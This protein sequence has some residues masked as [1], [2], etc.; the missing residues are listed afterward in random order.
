MAGIAWSVP[1]LVVAGAAPAVSASTFPAVVVNQGTTSDSGLPV[2]RHP[3][4]GWTGPGTSNT[5]YVG[6]NVPGFASG[7]DPLTRFGATVTATYTFTTVKGATYSIGLDT[8]VGLGWPADRAQ[9]ERLVV[10]VGNTTIAQVTPEHGTQTAYAANNTDTYWAGQG[11]SLQAPS[12]TAKVHHT[13][14]FAAPPNGGTVTITYTFTLPSV[15]G[16][17][18]RVWDDIWASAP[19]VIQIS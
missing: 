17:T 8:M 11:Y 15:I 4:T 10:T 2:G 13:G 16:T 9:R 1:V 19:T 14:T 5:Y 12:A 6:D 3:Y 7:T 18:L